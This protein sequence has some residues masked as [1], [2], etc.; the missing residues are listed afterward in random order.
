MNLTFIVNLF[1][2]L[3]IFIFKTTTI[4]AKININLSMVNMD[5]NLKKVGNTYKIIC[6][7]LL[8]NN[9]FRFS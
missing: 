3:R 6:L 8:M 1:Q 9:N 4:L 2:I 7:S 5:M